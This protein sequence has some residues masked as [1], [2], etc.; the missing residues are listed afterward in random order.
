MPGWNIAAVTVPLPTQTAVLGNTRVDWTTLFG[1][2]PMKIKGSSTSQQGRLL[3]NGGVDVQY[4]ARYVQ[5][6]DTESN[7]LT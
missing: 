7:L 1:L 4:K 3:Q 2:L 6:G 5:P